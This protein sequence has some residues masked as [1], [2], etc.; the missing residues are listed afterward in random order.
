MQRE[1]SL[2]YPGSIIKSHNFPL[3]QAARVNRIIYILARA[4]V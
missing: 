4:E 1:T 2:S 3:Y